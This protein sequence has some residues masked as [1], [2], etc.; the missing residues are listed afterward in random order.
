MSEGIAGKQDALTFDSTP[1]A[2]SSNPVTSDRIYKALTNL[3]TSLASITSKAYFKGSSLYGDCTI[4][5]A[6]GVSYANCTVYYS[7]AIYLRSTSLNSPSSS[8]FT[9]DSGSQTVTISSSSQKINILMGK[10]YSKY[11]TDPQYRGGVH[12]VVKCG[13]QTLDSFADTA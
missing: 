2:G 6:S 11:I 7:Y 10:L 3:R 8:A 4:T 9:Q 12:F 5:L 13:A 1:T